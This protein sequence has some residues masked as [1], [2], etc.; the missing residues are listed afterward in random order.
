MIK[1]GVDYYPEHWDRELWEK[2]IARMKKAGV[3]VVRIA[4]FAWSRLEPEEGKFDF[5]WL[6]DIVSRL[7]GAGLEIILGT[8]TNC[9]PL[10][11]YRSRP[12]TLQT[13]RTGMKT[14][15]GIRGHRCQ[16]SPV[17]RKYAGRIVAEM[18][19]R[20]ADDLAVVAWQI[21]NEIES[22]HCNCESCTAAF[23]AFLREK[24]G[25]IGRLNRAWGNDV[26][27]GDFSSFDEI[28][29]PLGDKY[30]YGWLNPSYMLDYER[31]AASSTLD[32][33]RFQADILRAAN[34]KA[35]VTTNGCFGEHTPDYY[36]VFEALD[37]A[38]YDNYPTLYRTE[39]NPNGKQAFVLD[40]IRGYKRQNF[41][42]MEQMS[43]SFGCWG[44]IS[45]APRPGAIEGYAVQAI[46]HGADL[47]MHFRWRTS[48]RGAEMFCHG[49]LDHSDADN[50]RLAEFTRLCARVNE[51]QIPESAVLKSEV[52]LLYSYEQE[53]A[54]KVQQM[55]E[56]FTY[57]R[58][59]EALHAA[60][61]RFGVNID[62]I[63]Q[64]ADLSGYKIVL[65]PAHFVADETLAKKLENFVREGGIAVVTARSGVKD[66]CNACLMRE[67]P[68]PFAPLCGAVVREYDGIGEAEVALKGANGKNYTATCWCD[69]LDLR[70]AEGYAFYDSEYYAGEPAASVRSLGKGYAWYIG[71][72]CGGEFYED[73][74][75]DTLQRAGIPF[76]K[77]PENVEKTIREDDG[78]R[79]VFL[80]NNGE[81]ARA[82]SH[83]GKTVTLRP[84]EAAVFKERK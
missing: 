66:K 58:Q 9:A 27:S 31:F 8:P 22:N 62:V 70:G 34:P 16:T 75:A 11:L 48:V 25:D 63:E 29:T 1:I 17:F 41:W 46:A 49:L 53:Y 40:L 81:E 6:D 68:G 35:V 55:S 79:F 59:A 38:S 43:G 57:R 84:Y 2:D 3:K 32:Y 5:G 7:K 54:F 74:A 82:F 80:F 65:L 15:T 30:R 69:V 12:E 45:P 83:G 64:T 61:K 44:P 18:A 60:Y 42:V 13:E 33:I 24:Y 77:L 26:W 50:R 67:L 37:V 39:K 73:L 23:R 51:L 4:E 14:E 28:R 52:A 10:W 76:E 71:A 36:R 21:D 72:V 56:G 47:V 20:Y 19:R 78:R